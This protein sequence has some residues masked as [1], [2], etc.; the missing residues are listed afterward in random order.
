M[1]ALER[2]PGKGK[3]SG[4][5]AA[6]ADRYGVDPLLI[7]T[8]FVIAALS[9][10]VG[11]VLYLAGWMLT[12]VTTTG[13]VPLDRLGTRWRSLS[14]RAL[15]GWT[16]ALA[17][18]TAISLGTLDG[19]GWTPLIIV[20]VTIW[21]GQRIGHRPSR[22]RPAM[23]RFPTAQAAT[24]ARQRALEHGSQSRSR[25]RSSAASRSNKPLT[26]L[27]ILLSLAA[28]G[29]CAALWPG[30]PLL[31]VSAALAVVGLG[32]VLLAWR[33]RSLAL[34]VF[35]VVCSLA[36]VLTAA[37]GPSSARTAQ[38]YGT[39]P[40]SGPTHVSSQYS[41]LDA[42]DVRVHADTRWELI[43]TSSSV[44][45]QLPQD[46]NVAVETDYSNSA[47]ILGNHQTLLGTGH[48]V[49]DQRPDLNGQTLIVHLTVRNSAVAVRTP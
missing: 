18:A 4:L 5:C 27:V 3:I 48:A 12:P 8:L 49:W 9:S 34:I 15:V 16:M 25:P 1:L 28:G 26:L 33:G 30:N 7:R 40:P 21:T 24:Q 42:S 29:G 17:A 14:P 38:H 22:R 32:V 39:L 35:G 46:T 10:G 45:L 47:I 44:V 37:A 2:D 11:V 20:V 41:L 13:K 19:L 43:V 6:V 31:V 36:L 23:Y